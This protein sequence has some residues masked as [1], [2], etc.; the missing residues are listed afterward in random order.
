QTLT[1]INR[2]LRLHRFQEVQLLETGTEPLRALELRLILLQECQNPIGEFAGLAI[3]VK[4]T[5]S[6]PLAVK[7]GEFLIDAQQEPIAL[8]AEHERI[9]TH[10]CWNILGAPRIAVREVKVL[11][12]ADA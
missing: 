12:A 1:G 7:T 10:E 11:A 2:D 5:M 3:I 8:P 4:K 9:T 6:T